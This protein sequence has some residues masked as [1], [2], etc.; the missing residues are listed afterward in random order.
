MKVCKR[1]HYWGHVQGVGFRYTTL[2]LAGQFKVTGY[3]SNLLDGQVELLV[4]G[5]AD[6]VERFLQRVT[7]KMAGY[8]KGQKVEDATP[9][10]MTTFTIR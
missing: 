2:H 9:V 7:D 1:V 4:E 3:V 10:E 6:E 5:E 8:I